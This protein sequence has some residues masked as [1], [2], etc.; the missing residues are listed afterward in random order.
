V[1]LANPADGANCP[2]GDVQIDANAWAGTGR[3]ISKV[4]FFEGANKLGEALAAPYHLTWANVALGPHTLSAVA[5]DNGGRVMASDLVTFTVSIPTISTTLISA[6]S[7]WKYL[8]DGSNQGT[9]WAQRSFNDAGWAFGPARLGYGGDGEAT[10]LSYGPNANSKYLTY[11][12]RKLFTVADDLVI[13]NLGFRLVRDDGAVGYLNGV[14]VF[15]SNMPI[16]PITYTT[17]ASTN[18]NGPDEQTFF[19][20][21]A[22][23]ARLVSGTNV[24][25]VEV[26]QSGATSSDLGF[27]FEL[28]GV[29]YRV[30]PPRLGIQ[31][32]S[33]NVRLTWPS[34]ATNWNLYA[35]PELSSSSAWT[36]VQVIPTDANGFKSVTVGGDG[37][38]RFYRL[39]KP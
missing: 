19:P 27:N 34:S 31:N 7:I 4:E 10:V 2:P 15:R 8:D 29:G 24:L 36:Q 28:Y 37:P 32:L 39:Q 26:H 13:T 20:G 30:P 22:S 25:A 35:T 21:T 18:N 11:Y 12:F 38:S 9:N 33:G 17:L 6:G 23:A 3:T 5:T 1:Y 14:E 16:G